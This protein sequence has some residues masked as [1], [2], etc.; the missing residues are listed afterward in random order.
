MRYLKAMIMIRIN[1]VFCEHTHKREKE[2]NIA[3]S[4]SI[5]VAYSGS[6]KQQGRAANE[7]FGLQVKQP[8]RRDE[9]MIRK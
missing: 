9:N 2:N 6:V 8:P 1:V 5:I 3:I 4:N 7:S